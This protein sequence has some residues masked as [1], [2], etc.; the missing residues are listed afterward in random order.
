MIDWRGPA[1]VDAAGSVLAQPAAPPPPRDTP[2][3]RTR[4]DLWVAAVALLL[5]LAWDAS[6][7]DLA[8]VRRYGSASGFPWQEHWFTRGLLHQG[9][10]W[11]GFAVLA[12][13]VVN[14]RWPV[15]PRLSS[16]ERWRWLGLTLL[17]LLLV[18][19]LKRYSQ[20]SCPWS[21]AEF[22]GVA[23]YVSHWQ[24]G[25]SD[26]GPGHCFP[27]GHATSA[28]A[29]FSGYFALRQAYPVAARRWLAGALLLGVVFGWAQMAR[30]A[31]YPSHAMWTAWFCWAICAAWAGVLGMRRRRGPV[32]R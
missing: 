2:A 3:G 4:R 19:T 9:G 13:L 12:V 1:P 14:L 10:R 11:L 6:G 24:L 31:H 25:V 17:C 21:L 7:F 32:G 26:G 22:G 28:F 29:F 5:L 30:G 16:A 23:T 8:I 27:S 20:T 18:P 15:F